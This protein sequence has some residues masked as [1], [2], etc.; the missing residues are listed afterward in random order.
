MYEKFPLAFLS[1]ITTVKVNRTS[2]HLHSPPLISTHL[3]SPP[4]TSPG[5]LWVIWPA[6]GWGIGL[7]FH[8]M[9]TFGLI[10]DKNKEREM[11][12]KEVRR[13]DREGPHEYLDEDDHLDLREIEKE[14]RYNEDD[15]V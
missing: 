10:A 13:L 3:H 15:L 4:L 12:E 1:V 9:D 14:V 6:L 7:A 11:I 5:Y 8:A 2:T